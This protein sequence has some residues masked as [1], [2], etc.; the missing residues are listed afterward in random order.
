MLQ[1]FRHPMPGAWRS[2]LAR[3]GREPVAAWT[4]QRKAFALIAGGCAAIL[5][6]AAVL[7]ALSLDARLQAD[8]ATHGRIEAASLALAVRSGLLIEDASSLEQA[9]RL[10]MND[11]DVERVDVFDANGDLIFDGRRQGASVIV[12]QTLAAAPRSVG[13]GLFELAE[14]VRD[15][16]GKTLGRVSVAFSK[17]G[18]WAEQRR[19][20]LELG[21]LMLG[22]LAL[23]CLVSYRFARSI[24][25]PV[26]QITTTIRAISGSRDLSKRVEG[27][28][29]VVELRVLQETFNQLIAEIE[30]S[31]D[32]RLEHERLR[33]ELEIAA[34]I[35]AAL[36]PA[37]EAVSNAHYDVFATMRPAEGVGGDYFDIIQADGD[38]LWLGIGDVSGHGLSSG[39]TM[40]MAQSA[41]TSFLRARPEAGPKAL[42][43][44]LNATL[45]DNMRNRFKAD[46]FFTGCMLALEPDGRARHSGKHLPLIIFRQAAGACE[47]IDTEGLWMGIL[48]DIEAMLTEDAFELAPG[49]VLCLYTDG[50][51]EAKDAASRQFDLPAL[52]RSVEQHGP[53][54][55]TASALGQAILADLDRFIGDRPAADD[56]TLMVVRKT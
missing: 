18:I 42:V 5:S 44:N 48:P 20:I 41:V 50:L 14:M 9:V 6:V 12:G 37:A 55:R 47:L 40:M 54:A 21:L 3:R 26:E 34:G 36:L 39:L 15:A 19:A 1:A 10:T 8:F 35:Q 16:D 7:F 28:T 31:Q 27:E 51:L 11:P 30:A 46:D 38:R 4:L 49:D 23:G 25:R 33:K 22:C 32:R 52:L 43:A 56:V 2:P 45:Y 29:E 24:S 13:L 53:L 17:A